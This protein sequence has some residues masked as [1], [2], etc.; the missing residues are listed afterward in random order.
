MSNL[1]Y[2]AGQTIANLATVA[3][4]AQG[5]LCVYT[6]AT[7]PLIVDLLGWGAATGQSYTAIPPQRLHDT[8]PNRLAA[9]GTVAVQVTGRADIRSRCHCGRRELHRRRPGD[10]WL[11]HGL[12]VRPGLGRWPAT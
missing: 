3:L 4:N 9:G 2:A 8:R 1:N 11:P 5:R 12:P 10:R 6:S 7:T